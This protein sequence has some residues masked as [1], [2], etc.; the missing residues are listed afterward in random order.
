MIRSLFGA[1]FGKAGGA[2]AVGDGVSR[3]AE[4]FRPNA[5]RRMELGHAAYATAQA[6]YL[7]EFRNAGSG[8]FDGVVNGLNRLPRP[9]LALGTLGLFTHAMAAPDS[10]ARRMAALATVPEPLWW[11]L[12]AVVAFYF[13]A[14]EAHY[15]RLG[16]FTPPPAP[17][18][19]RAGPPVQ[20]DGNAALAEWQAARGG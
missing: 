18:Q 10:F 12:G 16:K 17:P 20:P 4:V 11:L 6:S 2:R 19:P 7:A 8:W 1:R 13:G 9:L 15:A 5:T 3:V 14:R